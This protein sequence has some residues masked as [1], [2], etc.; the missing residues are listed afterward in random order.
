VGKGKR[1]P[2]VS[3]FKKTFFLKGL[4]SNAGVI[5]LTTG[6]ALEGDFELYM[7]TMDNE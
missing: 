1:R 7:R 2:G 6:V 5:H 3:L 4:T